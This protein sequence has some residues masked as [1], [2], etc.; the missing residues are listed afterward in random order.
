MMPK[1]PFGISKRPDESP[2]TEESDRPRSRKNRR[3]DFPIVGIGASAGGLEA[4]ELFLKSASPDSGLAY[5]IIQHLDPNHESLLSELIGHVTTMRVCEAVDRTLVEPNCVY[6]IPPN[7]DLSILHGVLHTFDLASPRG[8]HMPIDHFFRSLAEDRSESAIGVI[9]SGAGSDGTQGLKAIKERAGI[10]LVQEPSSAKFDGMPRSAIDAG[11]ADIVALPED[12]PAR[13]AEYRLRSP[14]LSSG[15]DPLGPGSQ[16]AVDKIVILLRSRNGNDFSQYKQSTLR[17]R[18]ERRMGIHGI[19]SVD[20]YVRFVQDNP[21]ELDLLFKE[22]LIGVTSFFRDR[23]AWDS[24]SNLALRP[25]FERGAEDS[26]LRAWSVGCSTG[27]EAYSLAMAFR[28]AEAASPSSGGRRIKIFA[29][30]LDKDAI[31][32]A[33]QGFYSAGAA[34]EV[35]ARRLERFFVADDGGFRVRKEIREMV[36]FAPQNAI[37]D[38]P[39]TR[40][41]LICCRNLL[42]YLAPDQQKK[43]LPLLHYALKPGG[44]L[45]LGSAESIGLFTELFAPLDAENRIYRVLESPRSQ[46]SP[47]FSGVAYRTLSDAPEGRRPEVKSIQSLADR[48]LLQRF[49]PAAVLTNPQGDIVYISG[50]TGRYLEPAAGKANWNI[51]AMAKPELRSKLQSAF[52]KALRGA[53][54]SIARSIEVACEGASCF[55]DM[56]VHVLDEPEEIMGCLMVVFSEASPPE[57]RGEPG[58]DDHA[59]ELERDLAEANGELSMLREEMQASQ[60][61][62]RASNEEL[63]SAN[64]ELQST[65]EELTTSREEMQSLNEELQ[66]VNSELQSKVDELLAVGD[67][68]KDLLDSTDIA[69]LFLDEELRVK[70]FTRRT[71]ALSKLIPADIGRVVTDISSELLY[72]EFVDDSK[73]VLRDRAVIEREIPIRDGSWLSARL[74]PYTAGDGSSEGIIVT[75]SDISRL[76]SLEAAV[77]AAK[78]PGKEDGL[79]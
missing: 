53:E 48:V 47:D 3:F 2:S 38:P 21:Q 25:L 17:R 70:R 68:V 26:S 71:A 6:T 9:L 75:F 59:S 16:G 5:V 37:M 22:L 13:I 74:I 73:K 20:T 66:T 69:M 60:E 46:S 54:S 11:L 27:E 72:P 43:L 50:S 40:L 63:Q 4:I 57:R 34:A 44:C 28:E 1:R 36:V 77:G 23:A 32:K 49:A 45:F 14:L 76:K 29:T 15:E 30:D 18:I 51:M 8:L 7:K 52:A 19:P 67:D 65:V 10:V 56:A 39:F 79:S 24:L 61:E 62:L 31:D 42:I 35:P 78:T 64:E 33:R 12:L 55:V 41:D 58:G